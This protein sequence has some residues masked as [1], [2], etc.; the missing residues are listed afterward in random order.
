MRTV[1]LVLGLVLGLGGIV[2]FPYLGVS[3]EAIVNIGVP[4]AV[5]VLYLITWAILSSA[6]KKLQ[7]YM[8]VSKTAQQPATTDGTK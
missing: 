4:G 6:G 1:N 2:V 5:L 7:S 8:G 3:P